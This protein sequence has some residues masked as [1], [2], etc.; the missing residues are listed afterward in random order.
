MHYFVPYIFLD[1]YTQFPWTVSKL[2]RIRPKSRKTNP[3]DLRVDKVDYY[4][5]SAIVDILAMQSLYVMEF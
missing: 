1:P 5:V 4:V 2:I 3:I